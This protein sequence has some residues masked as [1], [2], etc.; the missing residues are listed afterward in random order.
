MKVIVKEKQT[1]IVDVTIENYKLCDKCNEKIETHC[2]DAFEC[3]LTH[4]NGS[5]YPTGGGGERQEM[6]LC[7]KCSIELVDFLRENG[8]RVNDSEWDSDC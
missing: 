1:K 5:I 7:Q 2:H 6:D 8:Y 4:T 3:K